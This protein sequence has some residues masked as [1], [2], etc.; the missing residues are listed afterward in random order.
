VAHHVWTLTW[1]QIWM[2]PLMNLHNLVKIRWSVI[3][4][5]SYVEKIDQDFAPCQIAEEFP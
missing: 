3:D 4:K 2:L 5:K 1:D